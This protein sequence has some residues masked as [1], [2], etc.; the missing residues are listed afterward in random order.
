MAIDSIVPTP[1]KKANPAQLLANCHI[2]DSYI[3]TFE[4][5][6]TAGI[7]SFTNFKELMSDANLSESDKETIVSIILPGD[8]S[9][10]G[11]SRALTNVALV[12]ISLAQENEELSIDAVDDRKSQELPF[13]KLSDR[14]TAAAA[15]EHN[16]STTEDVPAPA[17][18]EPQQTTLDSYITTSPGATATLKAPT[19]RQELNDPW[20]PN[21]SPSHT[22]RYDSLDSRTEQPSY[23]ASLAPTVSLDFDAVTIRALEGKEGIP[24]WKHINYESVFSHPDHCRLLI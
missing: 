11:L 21:R 9:S 5:Y 3:D 23:N 7:M 4:S 16:R 13:P 8:T 17:Q 2:P 24:L 14:K 12:L 19:E 18:P 15:K 10:S 6:S 20:S 22:P 1:K